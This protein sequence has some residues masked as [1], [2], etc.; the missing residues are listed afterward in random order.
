VN[1]TLAIEGK[2]ELE[3]LV[4]RSRL[5]GSDRSLVLHGGGNTSTKLFEH[6]HL[7]RER[8]AIRI[9]GS[10]ADLATAESRHFPALWLDEILPL[11][12]RDGM[13]D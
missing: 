10:G 12:E 8:R 13:S 2:T 11:Q 7:G 9:K 1:G 3:R 4:A 6:D 5:I